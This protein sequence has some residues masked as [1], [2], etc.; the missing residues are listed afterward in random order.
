MNIVFFSEKH[1]LH[2]NIEKL[3]L[4]IQEVRERQEELRSAK[5]VI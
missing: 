1:I 2:K 5:Q 3:S 4:E